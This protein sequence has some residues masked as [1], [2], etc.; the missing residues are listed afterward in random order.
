MAAE[1]H[2][3]PPEIPEPTLMENVLRHRLF[4]GSVLQ[5]VCVLAIILPASN[6]W[7][8]HII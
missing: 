3:W 2:F 5:L 7:S 8:F 6:S 1:R 4:Y